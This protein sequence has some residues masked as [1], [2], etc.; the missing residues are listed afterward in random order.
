MKVPPASTNRSS[1]AKLPASS[2]SAPK[3]IVPR[4]RVDT[5]VPVPPRVR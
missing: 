4:H 1:W 2:V 5:T 3:V